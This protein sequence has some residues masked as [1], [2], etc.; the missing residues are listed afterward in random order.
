M[1]QTCISSATSYLSAAEFLKR[2]DKRTVGQ[3][4]SDDDNIVSG[5]SLLT[6]EN[7]AAALLDASGDVES[8]ATIGGKYLPVDLAALSGAALGKLY[9]ILADVTIA[10]LI[11]RRPEL[12]TK[13]PPSLGRSM[14]WL[15]QLA[16]GTRIFAFSETMA[17]GR[18]ECDVTTPQEVEQRNLTT[19]QASRLFGRLADRELPPRM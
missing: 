9:R 19:F 8:A 13:D 1:A 17:A 10:Y 6:D 15:E 11:E 7:L 12:V 16:Q 4:V 5:S 3:L 14:V 18:P 2:C